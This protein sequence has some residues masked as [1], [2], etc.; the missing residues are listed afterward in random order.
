MISVFLADLETRLV[1]RNNEPADGEV[2]NLP[3][4]GRALHGSGG[5]GFGGPIVKQAPGAVIQ[6]PACKHTLASY[7]TL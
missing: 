5:V 3:S 7:V 4:R 2:E 6:R 1:A